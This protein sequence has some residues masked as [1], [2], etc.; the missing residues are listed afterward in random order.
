MQGES[1]LGPLQWTFE[2]LFLSSQE[3]FYEILH[4]CGQART[5]IDIEVYIFSN[6]EV[7]K[8][9]IE[10]L[11][12]AVKRG[13]HVRLLVDGIGSPHWVH[14]PLESLP[15]Q[16]G[17]ETRVYHPLASPWS[18]WGLRN[19]PHFFLVLKLLNSINRRNHKKVFLI[20]GE[21]AFVGGVNV[22]EASLNWKDVGVMV[23][24]PGV[25]DLVSAFSFN[26]TRSASWKMDSVRQPR[27]ARRISKSWR[28]PYVELNHTLLLRRSRLRLLVARVNLAARRVW[29]ANP[30]WVPSPKL[31]GAL[32]K[33][34]QRGVDVRLCFPGFTDVFFTRWVGEI[35]LAPL[36]PLGVKLHEYRDGFAHAKFMVIDSW[37]KLGSTN[38]NYRSQYHDL[39]AD[40]VL[41]RLDNIDALAR[42]FEEYCEQSNLVSVADVSRRPWVQRLIARFIL[43]FKRWI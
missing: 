12:K 9:L 15:E 27:A 25:R 35:L 17:I 24:G 43:I 2:K 6:D 23:E 4:S 13:V 39:E 26:W 8:R 30:Y 1:P 5:S 33:A 21:K 37:G 22:S 29:I 31:L 20:D 42:N 3:Y 28:N 38:L 14:G 34:A 40:V 10:E 18:R 11:E 32:I 36:I 19:F 41:S 7:G 16:A